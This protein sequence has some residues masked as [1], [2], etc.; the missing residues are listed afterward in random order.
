MKFYHFVLIAILIA[1]INTDCTSKISGS[2]VS[3]KSDCHDALSDTE[4]KTYSHC[5]YLEDDTGSSKACLPITKETF[6]GLEK[7][8][9]E[10]EKAGNKGKGVYDC[11]SS[12]IKIGLL[13][14]LFAVL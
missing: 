9:Q 1:Y 12:Y 3:K 10:A 5:C 8:F 14:L 7:V 2:G 13:S 11:N 4:K 6:D